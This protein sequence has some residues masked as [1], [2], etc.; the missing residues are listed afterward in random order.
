MG[1]GQRGPIMFTRK[2]VKTWLTAPKSEEGK[3]HGDG[4]GRVAG[5]NY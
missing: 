4:Q 3:T 1:P 2:D 5:R